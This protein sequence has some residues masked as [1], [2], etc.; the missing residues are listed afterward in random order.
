MMQ[1]TP[2]LLVAVVLGSDA[3][4]RQTW[5]GEHA[6]PGW[7][8]AG[9]LGGQLAILLIAAALVA[10]AGRRVSRGQVGRGVAIADRVEIAARWAILLVHA[11]AVLVLG[12]L[13][14]LRSWTGD[15][16]LIDELLALLPA[17]AALTGLWWVHY[18]IESR[19]RD[20]VLMRRLDEGR[21]VHAMPSRWSY[22]LVQARLHLL[23]LLVPLLVILGLSEIIERLANRL[24]DESSRQWISDVA[25]AGAALCVFIIAP[26]MARVILHVESLPAG[27]VRSELMQVCR[28]HRVKVRDILLWKTGGTMINAAV[29]GLV[30]PL[31]YV[32]ITDALLETMQREQVLAVMAH[33]IGHVRRRHV[34]WMLGALMAIVLLCGMLVF[35]PLQYVTTSSAQAASAVE[36]GATAAIFVLA[37]F[38]FGWVSRRFERQADAFAAQHLSGLTAHRGQKT[39]GQVIGERS[40]TA[41]QSALELVARLNA[42]DPQRP[43]W[44]HGSIRWRQ[45]NLQRLVGR[46]LRNLAIDRVV[47]QIKLATLLVLLAMIGYEAAAMKMNLDALRGPMLNWLED[48]SPG[49]IQHESVP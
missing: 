8:I 9:A 26:L 27:E 24:I 39:D 44:R 19:L 34:P 33:E 12:W 40:V 10:L 14:V 22:V 45:Q 4:L 11:V 36:L 38:V 16:E 43:S 5:I 37:A 7:A 15:I 20:A 17:T 23:L 32:L 47:A 30:S 46:P 21:P 2:I 29:M 18:P 49:D 35:L 41:V 48:D 25:S 42:I 6:Q 3:G 31:R 13:D 1:L 28:T